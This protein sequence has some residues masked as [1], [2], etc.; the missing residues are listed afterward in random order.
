MLKCE[1]DVSLTALRVVVVDLVSEEMKRWKRFA[2]LQLEVLHALSS[3]KYFLWVLQ[4]LT[5]CR[6]EFL[7]SSCDLI[8]F[9]VAR[10]GVE[11]DDEVEG[12]PKP[13]VSYR[14]RQ[15]QAMTLS[16][17]HAITSSLCV[18]GY[19]V[20]HCG[21]GL[22][23]AQQLEC[24][25]IVD[26]DTCASPSEM[27]SKFKWKTFKCCGQ[28]NVCN[29]DSEGHVQSLRALSVVTNA[30]VFDTLDSLMA[31]VRK[32]QSF[33][34]HITSNV[35]YL[36]VLELLHHCA[37]PSPPPRQVRLHVNQHLVASAGMSYQGHQPVAEIE[38]EGVS[39]DVNYDE[40]SAASDTKPPDFFRR[41]G[42]PGHSED[43]EFFG[44]PLFFS[45]IGALERMT[46]RAKLA[47]IPL[48]KQFSSH[49][50]IIS[51]GVDEDVA[52][53]QSGSQQDEYMFS[54]SFA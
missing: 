52:L 17:K 15:I 30:K 14:L 43:D 8:D 32:R 16:E 18:L 25:M 38:G 22:G 47:A 5:R 40:G 45:R 35:Y 50:H 2:S 51:V 7:H 26:F 3:N 21:R 42:T 41:G 44:D 54:V 6:Q 13:L 34:Q 24:P 27:S 20:T 53:R 39:T 11:Y 37:P 29:V 12:S 48:L 9:D 19:K 1:E 4:L 23:E 10:E 33:L 49:W 31:I 46:P 36:W 28:L